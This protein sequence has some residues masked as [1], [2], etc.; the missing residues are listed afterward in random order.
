M[1]WSCRHC[2]SIQNTWQ[3]TRYFKVDFDSN[4]LL[5]PFVYILEKYLQFRKNK[6]I[7]ER[8]DLVGPK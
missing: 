1:Q 3:Y 6:R 5:F 4:G 8:K 2:T 7:C